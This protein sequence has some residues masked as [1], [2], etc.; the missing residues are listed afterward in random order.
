MLEETLAAQSAAG[1]VL[2][3]GLDRPVYLIDIYSSVVRDGSRTSNDVWPPGAETLLRSLEA[4]KRLRAVLDLDE[5]TAA[6]LAGRAPAAVEQIREGL[7]SGRLELAY[8][9]SRPLV[10]GSSG[11]S[12][13]RQLARGPMALRDSLGVRAESYLLR[14]DRAFSQLPQL[15][16]SLGFK[17]VIVATEAS[18]RA[19]P[20]HLQGPDGS[21]VA[22]AF[23]VYG[24]VGASDHADPVGW[25]NERLE[26]FRGEMGSMTAP[27]LCRVNGIDS[28]AGPTVTRA[29][30]AARDDLRFVTPREYFQSAAPA[31]M[32]RETVVMGAGDLR[33]G[34]RPQGTIAAA[35]QA[36]LL[37]ERLDAFAYAMGRESDEKALEQVWKDLLRAQERAPPAD[38]SQQGDEKTIA[39]HEAAREVAETAAKYLA[40]HVDS[41]GLQGR[42]L[43]VFN[44]SPRPRDEYMEVTLGGEGYRILQGGRDVASQIVERRDGYV[45]LGFIA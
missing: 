31:A 32:R 17:R 3:C 28:P 14:E 30:I 4:N 19:L 33:A 24:A 39:A 21:E 6:D 43:V 10:A 18:N 2:E 12:V 34:D 36:L 1:T 42:G 9:Y 27:V 8:G 29:A 44:P 26:G 16:A 22:T 35:E 13:I 5:E 45:T 20:F 11:E 23:A 25:S 7:A 38:H 15:L 41:S 37:A 40:S